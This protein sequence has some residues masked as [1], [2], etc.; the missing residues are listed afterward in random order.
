MKQLKCEMCGSTDV[1]KQDGMFV[2]QV[3]GT[4][5]SV[6]EAKK[7]MIEGTVEV[8]GTVKIDNSNQVENILI[9]A[10]RAYE[11]DKRD[12]TY[13]LCAQA[14]SINP[15][16]EE[17]ILYQA[18]AIGW[19]S[20]TVNDNYS[21]A[22]DGATRA[23]EISTQNL[24]SKE[25]IVFA[26]F[27]TEELTKICLALINMC[28]EDKKEEQASYNEK[29]K[30]Y[31]SYILNSSSSSD[32]K[33]WENEGQ[34]ALNKFNSE[35]DRLCKVSDKAIL[36]LLSVYNQLL[37]VLNDASEENKDDIVKLSKFIKSMLD[38]LHGK[39]CYKVTTEN[40]D[41]TILL[42]VT[43]IGKYDEKYFKDFNNQEKREKIKKLESNVRSNNI[44]IEKLKVNKQDHKYKKWG[45]PC[46]IFGIIALILG[47]VFVNIDTVVGV[48][49]FE[50]I[51][52]LFLLISGIVWVMP[53]KIMDD[54]QAAKKID[55]L[56]KSNAGIQ[57]EIASIQKELEE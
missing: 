51:A 1:V 41:N 27:A 20:N 49:I 10:K 5:Y 24:Q 50:I 44:T 26:D 13:Q 3:C 22:I 8:T 4:K 16:C 23:L 40:I 38:E 54:E 14:L 9:N 39:T 55:E 25:F 37:G 32:I 12:D 29:L 47:I 21:K 52:S 11:D 28:G 15:N 35:Y 6:E 19:K 18:L 31:K 36:G 30:R 46:I 56:T 7:M 57:N 43:L 45:M 2:C 33:H 48:G 42:T 53:K 34:E 17:A